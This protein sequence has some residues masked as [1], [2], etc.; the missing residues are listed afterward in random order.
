MYLRHQFLLS[1]FPARTV[2]LIA[3]VEDVQGDDAQPD[4]T[5]RVPVRTSE[6]LKADIERYI[7]ETAES[8]MKSICERYRAGER[9]EVLRGEV[10]FLNEFQK[11]GRELTGAKKDSIKLELTCPNQEA[12]DDLLIKFKTGQLLDTFHNAFGTSMQKKRFGVKE[13]NFSLEIDEAEYTRS[14]QQYPRR[15][16]R[17]S[18]YSEPGIIMQESV[19]I[20]VNIS[21]QFFTVFDDF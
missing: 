10:E 20:L 18:S 1:C 16:N 4:S 14:R 5:Q 21:N 8:G 17:I 13:L 2:N 7:L 15:G 6:Q 19:E 12:I 3:H 11:M 9:H